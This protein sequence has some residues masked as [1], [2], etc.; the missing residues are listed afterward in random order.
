MKIRF[1]RESRVERVEKVRVTIFWK[2]V[3]RPFGSRRDDRSSGFVVRVTS[4]VDRCSVGKVGT[5]ATTAINA[6]LHQSVRSPR[7]RWTGRCRG[8]RCQV[9]IRQLWTGEF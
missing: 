5:W 3:S 9:R 2:I 7:A 4:D 6:D 1:G 8:D